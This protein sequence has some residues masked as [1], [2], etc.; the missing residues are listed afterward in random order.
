MKKRAR[1]QEK[2]DLMRRSSV[3]IAVLSLCLAGLWPATARGAAATP[4]SNKDVIRK[5]YAA[6]NA[7][8]WAALDAIIASDAI[9]HD[10]T[11]GQA[12]GR[13][14]IVEALKSFRAAFAD[15]VVIDQLVASGNE[16]ADRLH[17]DSTQTGAFFG[18]PPSDKPVHIEAIEIWQ[19]ENGQVV[20]GWHIENILQLLIQIGAVPSPSGR[21][22]TPMAATPMM[23]AAMST[24]MA[25]PMASPTT[26]DTAANEAVVR[27]YYDA[28]NS[29]Q[30]DVFDTLIAADAVDHNPSTATQGPG[31]DGIRQAITALRTAFPDYR[32]MNQDL[33]AEG[34]LVAVRSIAQGTQTGPLL[35]IP[36]S[37]KPV[38]FETMDIWRVRNGQIVDVWHIEQL[39]NVLVQ[40]GVIPAPGSGAATPAT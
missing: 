30:L 21:G 33:F 40:V 12:P 6:Y 32:V 16:V 36:P 15:P 20:E 24:P 22:G 37:G 13:A 35:R 26:T 31:R 39:F 29:G 1:S 5:L 8:D 19:I 27:R 25:P 10:A 4:E 34:D 17:L 3:F 18:L 7:G 11:P 28:V 38:Q 9:D 2:E 23:P 14:G